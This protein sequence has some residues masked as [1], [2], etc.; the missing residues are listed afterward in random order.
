MR[1]LALAVG[2]AV[3]L[4]TFPATADII[5]DNG[6]PDLVSGYPSDL[7]LPNVVFEPF[8][9]EEGSATVTDLHWWGFYAFAGTP[10]TDNFAVFI[11]GDNSGEPDPTDLE[12]SLT[13]GDIGRTDT[14]DDIEVFTG[15]S[16]DVYEYWLDIDPLVLQ[17][18]VTYWVGIANATQLDQDDDWYWATSD[19]DSGDAVGF[20]GVSFSSLGSSFA[21][22]LTNDNLEGVI[23]E[24]ASMALLGLGLVGVACRARRR[25]R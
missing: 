10:G 15:F 7:D 3:L 16:V 5:Y 17:P 13:P 24:P 21:F 18:G 4:A 23:P 22:N 20:N 9:L 8:V 19:V 11:T 6:T 1:N 2:V 14:G 12:L 25:F